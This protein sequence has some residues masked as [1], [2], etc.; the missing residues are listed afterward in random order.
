MRCLSER[1]CGQVGS[2]SRETTIPRFGAPGPPGG[3]SVPGL[4]LRRIIW[5]DG[6]PSNDPDYSVIDERGHTVGRIYQTLAVGGGEAWH[7]TIAFFEIAVDEPPA[8]R[9]RGNPR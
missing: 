3:V 7:W 9:T 2:G 8:F 5:G 6:K 4:I 1:G